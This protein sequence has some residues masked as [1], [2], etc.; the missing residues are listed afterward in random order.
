MRVRSP[1]NGRWQ[2]VP[3]GVRDYAAPE[4]ARHSALAASVRSEFM[5]WGYAEVRTPPVEYLETI[6]RGAGAGIQDHLFK[7][8]DTGGEL[9]V[10]R[11][12]MTVPIARLAATRLLPQTASPLRLSYVADVFRGQ[13]EG[14]TQL[15]A[16]TQAGVEL[17]GEGT[18]DADAEVIAL[19]ATCLRRA[20]V[21][22]AVVHVGHLGFFDDLLAALPAD[23][24]DEIRAR[25]YRKEFAGIE[26]A[27][28]DPSLAGLLRLLPD[29]HGDDA[30]TRATPFATSARSLAA[31]AD[32]ETLMARLRD[33]GL[34]D[35]VRFDLSIIRDF[36]YY[37]GVVFEAYGAGSGYPLAGGG[38]YDTLL[39][40]FGAE[41]PA[42][43]FALGLDR[44][45]SVLPTDGD[46][47]IAV[48]LVADPS[49]RS[50]AIQ[51]ATDLRRRG[52]SVLI[53]G[54]ADDAPIT[55]QRNSYQ[56]VV[57][58]TVDGIVLQDMRTETQRLVDRATLIAVLGTPSGD[59]VSEWT[60]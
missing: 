59:R 20:G 48:V 52:V 15:R 54:A 12:E 36:S 58:M 31:L 17:L 8:V 27:I 37:T 1:L 23:T 26:H 10:L 47:S 25:L 34:A 28:P 46:V 55:A 49:Q 60:R 24:Q 16:F 33:Y 2:Q 43:G 51:I 40:R 22:D 41:C 29:L 6:V 7:I 42:T 21:P 18:L 38:R 3:A 4:A 32:L 30:V 50:D 11:P 45:L 39:G 9:L 35:I 44:V 57:R 19:A 13:N 5:R 53:L 56:W 14:R